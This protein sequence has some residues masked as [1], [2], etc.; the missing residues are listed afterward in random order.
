MQD[1]VSHCPASPTLMIIT[2]DF[3]LYIA[4]EFRDVRLNEPPQLEPE[5]F[6]NPA[7]EPHP[8]ADCAR[9]ELAPRVVTLLRPLQHLDYHHIVL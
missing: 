9:S 1:R 4:F 3:H 2:A 7:V 5:L 6:F 8:P